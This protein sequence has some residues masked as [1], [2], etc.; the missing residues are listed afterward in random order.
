MWTLLSFGT[1]L[2]QQFGGKPF[3]GHA[4]SEVHKEMVY[5]VWCGRICLACTLSPEH[6]SEGL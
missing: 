3:L 6:V 2:L 4:Q 1:T 5:K